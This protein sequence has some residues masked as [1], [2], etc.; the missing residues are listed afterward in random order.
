M[1][2]NHTPRKKAALLVL[3]MLTLAASNASAIRVSRDASKTL[4]DRTNMVLLAAQAELKAGQVYTGNLAKAIAHQ[5]YATELWVQGNFT[6]AIYHSRRARILAL[7]V[8]NLN[9]GVVKAD[10]DFNKE[11][12]R[13]IRQTPHDE[14]LDKVLEKDLNVYYKMDQDFI[15]AVI[16]DVELEDVE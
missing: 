1:K 16:D 12:Q 5:R 8:I 6:D 4:L 15:T 14:Q 9:N 3:C 7:S 10:Y 13:Y 11:E 2:R